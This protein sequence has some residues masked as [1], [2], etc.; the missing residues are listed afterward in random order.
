MVVSIANIIRQCSNKWSQVLPIIYGILS[1]LAGSS[2]RSCQDLVSG[3]VPPHPPLYVLVVLLIPVCRVMWAGLGTVPH[4][5]IV[6]RPMAR[7]V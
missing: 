1:R 2:L 5:V 6:E 3:P 4:T 7:Q